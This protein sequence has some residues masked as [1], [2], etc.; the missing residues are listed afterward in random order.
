MPRQPSLTTLSGVAACVGALSC[1]ATVPRA[2]PASAPVDTV[3]VPRSDSAPTARKRQGYTEAD[4]RFMQGMIAHHAQAISMAAMVPART[5]RPNMR[6]LAERI[7]VSQRD[8]IALMRHWLETRHED[9]PAADAHRHME[10]GH[11]ASMPGMLNEEEL[12][13]LEKSSGL[14]FERLFLQ[15]MI[16]HHEG[17]LTMV[18][19][20]LAVRGAGQDPEVFRF[21]ADVDAD[22]RAEILRMQTLQ[23]E[24]Q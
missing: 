9:V 11:M 1:H 12:A 15:Y 4:V 22:Q 2:A 21:A 19:E 23:R 16:R 20:L 8:E 24:L 5:S 7:T 18:A 10:A 3:R 6:L 14:E 17:A 13:S